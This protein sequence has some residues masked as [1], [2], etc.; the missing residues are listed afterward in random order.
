M[1]TKMITPGYSGYGE[2]A[3]GDSEQYDFVLVTSFSPTFNRNTIKSNAP[4]GFLS[5][6]DAKLIQRT[7]SQFINDYN[8]ADISMSFQSTEAI[9]NSL[10]T[11]IKN[12]RTQ[13]IKI[14]F[15]D[16]AFGCSLS[17]SECYLKSFSFNISEGGILNVNLQLFSLLGDSYSTTISGYV[18][19]STT[20]RSQKLSSYKIIPYYK[21]SIVGINNIISYDFNY[22]QDVNPRF[23]MI[24]TSTNKPYKIIFGIPT[25]SLTYTKLC[26]DST[27]INLR[28]STVVGESTEYT[29]NI[30]I[31][32]GS[33]TLTC[34]GCLLQSAKPVVGDK[35]SGVLVE[36][37]YSVIK[38]LA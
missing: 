26:Y 22:S 2:I 4:G 34:N 31:K 18:G 11:M 16:D 6:K 36:Y 9:V 15:T 25:V 17:Y 28:E 8:S 32:I 20:N 29:K 3:F 27:T 24:G 14:K 21:C 13:I 7:V 38:N 10:F 23:G 5:G 33:K 12:N 1:S 30:Q 19:K 37:T 35:S